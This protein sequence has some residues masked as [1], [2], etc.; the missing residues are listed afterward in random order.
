MKRLIDLTPADLERVAVWRYGGETD[1]TANVRATDRRELDG[2]DAE[3]FIARTQ[4]ALANGAQHIGFCSPGRE[5]SLEALQP[6]ILTESG[7]VYFWFEDPPSSESLRAQWKRL[8]SAREDIFPVH[9]RCT[10]PVA[11][12]Y[13]TGTIVAGDLTGAA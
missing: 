4:F 8:G 5:S 9:F 3:L 10:V 6:V 2:Q 1:E 13:I 11:G 12:Q 7:P